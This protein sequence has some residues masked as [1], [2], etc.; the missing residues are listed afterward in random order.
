MG[1][2]RKAIIYKETDATTA[3]TETVDIDLSEK[4]SRLQIQFHSTNNGH[5]PTAV[6]AAAVSKVEI[7]DGSDVL[8]SL[9][10]KQIEALMF[11]NGKKTPYEREFRNDVENYMVLDVPFGRRLWD[12]VLALDPAK[13]RNPQIKVT[14]NKANGGSAPDAATLQICADVFDEKPVSPIG[15]L[16][17]KEYYSFTSAASAANEYVDL[18]NDYPIRRILLQTIESGSWWENLLSEFELSEEEGKRKPI[19]LTTGGELVELVMDKYGPVEELYVGTFPA[20]DQQTIYTMVSESVYALISPI[21]SATVYTDAESAGG[22]QTLTPSAVTAYRTLLKGFIPHGVV[23]L[24]MGDLE[25]HNDWYDV[26]RKG[27]I[28]LRLKAAGSVAFNV[29]LEQLRKY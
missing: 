25:D 2:Y 12:T 29:V 8:Y 7:V 13:Y 16:M 1:N 18:P 14:H 28:K 4:I 20:V 27:K 24:D 23:P 6:H 17:A 5:T 9:S 3:K 15:Y 22:S 19:E 26:T 21:G 11:Y 10:G